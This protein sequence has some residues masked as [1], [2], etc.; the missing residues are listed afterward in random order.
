MLEVY[1]HT[2][3]KY[4]FG[5]TLVPTWFTYVFKKN[6]NQ[7]LTG[8]E[9]AIVLVLETGFAVTALYVFVTCYSYMNSLLTISCLVLPCFS[10][11]SCLKKSLR[12]A[13]SML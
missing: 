13:R 11:M 4:R 9:D 2:N 8:F 12:L 10:T 1:I 3:R 5:A 6:N 7:G